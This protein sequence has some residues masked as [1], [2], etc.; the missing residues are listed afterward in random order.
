MPA[1][2]AR[3]MGEVRLRRTG[4]FAIFFDDRGGVKIWVNYFSQSQIHFCSKAL[5]QPY[6][7]LYNLSEP[8]NTLDLVV[9][10]AKTDY[11]FVWFIN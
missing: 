4:A 1:R 8:Y 6:S 3:R 9:S 11:N 5:L 10:N 7:Q 2:N